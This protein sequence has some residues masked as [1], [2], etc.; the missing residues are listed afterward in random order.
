VR[1]RRARGP[2]VHQLL[3]GAGPYDAITN[4]A[5]AWQ[6]ILAE[7]GWAGDVLAA[8]RDP[9]VGSAVRDADELPGRVRPG[10]VLIL[11]YSAYARALEAAL[12]LPVRR[13]LAYHNITPPQYLWE[14][15]PLSAL[16]C[17]VGRRRMGAFARR[18]D[19]AIAP[20]EFSARDLR[21]AGFDHVHVDRALYLIDRDRLGARAPAP[22]P[23]AGGGPTILFVGRLAHNK[24]QDRLVKAFALYQ[25]H[26][27][28][29]ARLVLAGSPGGGTYG[30][31][32]GRLAGEA[33]ARDVSLPGAV[34][35]PELNSLYASAAAFACLS[36]H[37]GFCIPVL[38]AL[39]FGLPVVAARAA[40]VPEVAGDAAVLLDDPDLATV[41]EAIDLCVRDEPLRAQ[42]RRRGERRLAAFEP[43]RTAAAVRAAVAPLLEGG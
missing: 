21:A 4:Q 20:T 38:E 42:L 36:E 27:E 14:H 6:R 18:V 8:T 17:A 10:D 1:R 25:R 9:A 43:E 35:Q 22:D 5:L 26:R 40:A 31:Y 41:A 29:R 3:S 33:G 34:P 32:L 24:R 12:E 15:E 11:H 30:D 37:E 16:T 7:R 19:V 13:V 23:P 2:R 39:H 28:P